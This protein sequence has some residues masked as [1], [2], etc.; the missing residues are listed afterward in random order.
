M[1]PVYDVSWGDKNRPGMID[2][3]YG[4][5]PYV[6]QWN[7]NIQRELIKDLVVDIGYVGN[8]A[9]GLRNGQLQLVD[10]LPVSALSQYGRN[11]NACPDARPRGRVRRS[12][13]G[14]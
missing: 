11:L 14:H 2:P 9:T 8:K 4:K 7:V 12:R 13:H 5:T 1:P 10:Q 3:N 6:Q